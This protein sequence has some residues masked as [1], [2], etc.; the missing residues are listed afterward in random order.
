MSNIRKTFNFRDGVQVDDEV[1]VVRGNRVGVGTTSPDELLD[2]RGNAK[3]IGIITANNLEISGVST[4]S[5]IRVGS[6]ITIEAS[7]GII[8][9]TK[10]LGDGSTL[11]N[12]PT[13]QWVDVDVGL[14]FTSIY[15][16]GNVGVG[17]TDPRNSLQ[18]GGES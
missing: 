1:L 10:F 13:S 17:T 2:V 9:A 3:V 5:D 4:F 16:A 18:V 12:I 7:S 11:S 14:G 15:N 8:S 6:G